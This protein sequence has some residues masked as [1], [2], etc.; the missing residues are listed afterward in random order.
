MKKFLISFLT[1]FIFSL[2]AQNFTVPAL[3]G[4]VVDKANVLSIQ[5]KNELENACKSFEKKTGGQF[6]IC[7]VPNIE[8]E[9]IESASIK[10]AETWKIG[11]KD[12]DNGIIFLL[13]M[14]EREF[15]IEVG[16]GFEGKL[17]DAKAGNI[18]RIVIPKFKEKKWCEGIKFIVNSTEQ[19]LSG[20]KTYEEI[21]KTSTLGTSIKMIISIIIII[22]IIFAIVNSDDFP[23]SS[24]GGSFGGGSS[25]GSGSSFRG[26]GGSF[27]GGGFSGKF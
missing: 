10:V 3:T 25:G 19:I 26:G 2:Y 14:K 18:G 6:A 9:S 21:T 12:K 13:S 11:H 4:R 27:G 1:I 8:G 16:Y 5:E 7:I 24:S 22:L 23:S 20:E 15:R 17:N